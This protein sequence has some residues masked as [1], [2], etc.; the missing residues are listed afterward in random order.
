MGGDPKGKKDV[1]QNL[2]ALCRKCHN[3]FGDVPELKEKLIE[4]HNAHLMNMD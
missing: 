3:E 4:I 1:I 2:Q